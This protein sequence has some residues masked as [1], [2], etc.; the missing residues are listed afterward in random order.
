[1]TM[2]WTIDPNHTLIEFSVKHMMI[3]TVR[4]R[5]TRFSGSIQLDERQPERAGVEGS[6]EVDSIDTHAADRDAHLRSADFFDVANHPRMTFR[7]TA[8]RPRAEGRFAIAGDL[9]IRGVTR[10][11]VFEVVDEGRSQDPWG[12]RRWG[13]SAETVINRKDFGL[14]WNVALETGGWLVGDQVRVSVELQLIEALPEA[15]MAEE[16]EPATAG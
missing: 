5:F 1:M 11:V 8:I 13:L 14:N 4:G 6:V 15:L 7:S 12:K 9:T 10:P 3:T 16:T 2:S